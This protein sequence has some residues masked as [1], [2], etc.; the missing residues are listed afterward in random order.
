[1]INYKQ[2]VH[3]K[4]KKTKGENMKVN[5]LIRSFALCA[6]ML[7]FACEA[8]A[9]YI[10]TQKAVV[11]GAWT[12]DFEGAKAYAEASN[13]PMI[14]FWAN[15]GCSHCEGI[16]KEM[17]KA[18][19]TEW[20]NE[21]KLL[22]VFVESNSTVKKWIKANARTTIKAY[23]YMAVYWPRNSAG[24]LILEGFSAYKGNMGLYGA[25]SK[26][27]NIQQIIDTIEYLIPD[28]DP[29]GVVPAPDPVFYT[30]NFV[31]DADKGVAAGE[32]S[33]QVESGKSAVAPTVTANDGWDFTGWDKTFTKVTADMTVN[34]KFSAVV[35]DPDPVFYT[36]NFVV[37]PDKGVAEG[38]LSQQ[39]ESGK[40]A[41][42]PTVTANEGW[43][44]VD[45]DKS[46]SKVKSDLTVT[47]IFEQPVDREEIDPAVFF[48]K[49]KTLEAIA[50][51]DGELFGRA[52]ITL[53]KYNAKRKYLKATFKIT[54]FAG[55]SYSKSLNLVPNEYGDFLEVDVAFKSPIGA[56]VFD[57]YN[58]DGGY[59]ILG[60]G[61]DYSVESG[62]DIVLG[63]LLENE[64]MTFSAEFDELE[65]ENDNYEFLDEMPSAF[66]TVKGGK[67]LNFGAAPKMSYKKFKE[68]GE[69]WYE[70]TEFDEERY[71]NVNA[72]KVTYKP[73]TGAFSGSFKMY[74]TNELA[75][76]DGK[77]PT[78]KTYTAKFSGYVVNGFGIGTV[79][80]KIGRKTYTG[81]CALD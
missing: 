73:A 57:L 23:P 63:G 52:A 51:K 5:K 80:V 38:E 75:I 78:L 13:I 30:V 59:E 22:M 3:Q 72:V 34:A 19:F 65:P 68:D 46:F 48:K 54:S 71:P 49:A 14:V 58:G 81:T 32:L 18:Y 6:S 70:L 62:E 1:M 7:L 20:M 28:W 26:D 61:D 9:G 35:P 56:M 29:N 47:A 12:S 33:Q 4:H 44:F 66:A 50:Y 31:V 76:D 21:R 10:V 53:G 24:E 60:E 79:S 42:A 45:W 11:P 41:V 8:M 27:S 36:V 15:A 55:T 25:S 67:T 2:R 16:E 77:K 74:A 43:E 37:D 17:N 64:E 39:V 40:A 69:T